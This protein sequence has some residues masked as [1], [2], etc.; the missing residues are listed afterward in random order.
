MVAVVDGAVELAD[1][2]DS[3][4]DDGADE[5]VD[6]ELVTADVLVVEV[7]SLSERSSRLPRPKSRRRK[8][9][10]GFSGRAVGA[11]VAGAATPVAVVVVVEVEVVVLVG[12][13]LLDADVVL[14]SERVLELEVAEELS[15][16]STSD[17]VGRELVSSSSPYPLT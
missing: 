14:L 2:V 11:C 4:V 16:V 13:V 5:V 1:D 7:D 17:D 12:L 10:I 8:A 6:R 9:T 3:T 15:E